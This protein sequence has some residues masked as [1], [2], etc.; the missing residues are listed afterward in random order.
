MDNK[1]SEELNIVGQVV[2]VIGLVAVAAGIIGIAAESIDTAIAG[3]AI[4]GGLV[5][6]VFGEILKGLSVIVRASETF[7]S[8]RKDQ[9]PDQ[10][11]TGE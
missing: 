5:V 8:E 6:A 9:D 2:M 7:I 1:R 11:C 4:A 3:S 10:K